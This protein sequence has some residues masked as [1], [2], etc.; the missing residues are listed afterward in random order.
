MITIYP[1]RKIITMNVRRPEAS[2]VA[3]LDGWILGAGALEELTGW[4]PHE[5]DDRFADKV[6]MPGLVEG[7]CHS[8]EGTGW[9]ETYVGFYDRTDPDRVVHPGLESIDEVVGRL[10][11]AERAL[12][13]PDEPLLAW[14]LDP[15]FFGGRRMVTADLDRVSATRPVLV[16]HQSGHIINANGELMRRAGISRDNER[17]GGHEGRAG[18]ADGRAPGSGAAFDAVPGGRSRPGPRLRRHAGLV[19]LRPLGPD[20]GSH[21]R[22]GPRER[23]SGGDG[24]G[25]GRGHLRRCVP[26]SRRARVHRHVAAGARRG[27]MGQVT[28]FAG[29]RAAPVRAGQAR[30]RRLDPGLHRPAQ[31]ARLL[32]RRGERALVHRPRRA[33]E[34]ARNLPPGGAPG[35]YPHQRRPSDGGRDRRH[36]A[37]A[38]GV[39]RSGCPLHPAALPDGS[40]RPL[41][42]HGAARDLRE[43]LRQP[44]LLLGRPALRA[45]DGSGAGGAD[46]RSGERATARGRVFHPFR[47]PGDP[48]RTPLHGVVRG[49]TGRRR[50][51][52]SS[53]R[54]SG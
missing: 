10:Q 41:P 33:P 23:A 6:I 25:P 39:P 17:H 49:S 11:E 51:G 30:P 24:G 43:P 3:V 26:A 21:H 52:G 53:A 19:A 45:H 32:Q 20:R 18:R 29:E 15:L 1:A 54:R 9:D 13:D 12:S 28:H 46:G 7:H 50:R 34:H 38:E 2:H 16:L 4:G 5:I 35:A 48:P 40:R 27:R 47:R 36:R 37:G 31:V 22:N 42:P 14:G 8:R 44:P